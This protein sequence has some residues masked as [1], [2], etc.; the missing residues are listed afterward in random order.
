VGW[1]DDQEKGCAGEEFLMQ[2][3]IMIF[4]AEG[5]GVARAEPAKDMMRLI[6]AGELLGEASLIG[7][8]EVKVSGGIGASLDGYPGKDQEAVT[9]ALT[10][11]DAAEIDAVL[12]FA[13]V[14]SGDKI[15]NIGKQARHAFDRQL[16]F[17]PRGGGSSGLRTWE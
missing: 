8:V 17:L 13:V 9:V 1:A 7:G 12:V 14:G 15:P 2:I 10:E 4:G 6:Q 3:A 16:A 5:A 11:E